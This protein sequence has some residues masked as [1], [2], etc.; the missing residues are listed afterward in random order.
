MT[1]MTTIKCNR[2]G[3]EFTTRQGEECVHEV[4]FASTFPYYRK[5][6]NISK[7]HYC[8]NCLMLLREF[9]D[10]LEK[11]TLQKIERFKDMI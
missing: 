1:I 5:M 2:C 11:E 4:D 7:I 8:G 10:R 3:K 6:A 9:S